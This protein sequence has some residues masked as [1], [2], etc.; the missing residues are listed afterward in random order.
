MN[1]NTPVSWEDLEDGKRGTGQLIQPSTEP[2]PGF[3]WGSI[4][5]KLTTMAGYVVD[6]LDKAPTAIDGGKLKLLL[7]R[8]KKG[9]AS[10]QVTE[11]ASLSEHTP[12]TAFLGLYQVA[13][14][15]ASALPTM[16]VSQALEVLKLQG[17][18]LPESLMDTVKKAGIMDSPLNTVLLFGLPFK[19]K[20]IQGY[21]ARLEE[22]D[23]AH[24]PAPQE[25]TNGLDG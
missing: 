25:T 21:L 10:P 5:D 3:D 23:P 18:T 2:L 20:E 17:V 1:Q 7:E 9:M 6:I 8:Q 16:T 22:L 14:Y 19:Q 15:I 11:Q 12:G 24:Q 4:I 13:Q